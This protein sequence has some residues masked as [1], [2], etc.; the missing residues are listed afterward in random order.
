MARDV[1]CTLKVLSPSEAV[2][3]HGVHEVACISSACKVVILN[4]LVGLGP[5]IM[6]L[7]KQR[8]SEEAINSAE[9]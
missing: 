6:V 4:L 3:R 8:T 9:S 7:S 1:S 5:R 2:K